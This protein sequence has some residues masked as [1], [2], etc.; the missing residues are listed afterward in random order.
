MDRR[1]LGSLDGGAWRHPGNLDTG[2]P[3]RYDGF[4]GSQRP[5][6]EPGLGSSASFDTTGWGNSSFTTNVTT[7][8]EHSTTWPEL[9]NAWL[10]GSYVWFSRSD[11]WLEDSTTHFNHSLMR[12]NLSSVWLSLSTAWLRHPLVWLEHYFSSEQLIHM[13]IKENRVCG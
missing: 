11:V 13:I 4:A 8:T 10:N 3:C 6:W 12:V 1:N 7:P 5:R 2:D 9:R